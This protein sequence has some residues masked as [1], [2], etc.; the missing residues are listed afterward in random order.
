MSL[1]TVEMFT[2]GCKR[3]YM[4]VLVCLMFLSFGA[5][6]QHGVVFPQPKEMQLSQ[7]KIQ[8]KSVLFLEDKK[9]VQEAIVAIRLLSEQLSGVE[10]G[11]STDEKA[12]ISVVKNEDFAAES[13]ELT[14]Q[15]EKITITYA[16]Q[17]GLAYGLI[18]LIQLIDEG[19]K[20]PI[21]RI[22]DQPSFSYRGLHLDCSRHFWTVSEI[23]ILLNQMALLKLNRF[24]WHLTDDQGWRLEIKQYP[25][26]TEIGAWR[27][28]T[29]IG[30]FG[31]VPVQ[32]EHQKYGG[33]YTQED[34]KN[35]VAYALLLG[36]EVIP[37]IE[38]PG[39]ARAALAAYPE[40]SCTE[41]VLPVAGT[42]GV[43]EDVFC[44]KPQTT[45][46]LK[47]VLTEVA[48]IFPSKLIH[49]GGDECPKTQWEKCPQ[50]QALIAEKHLKNEHELQNYFISEMIQHLISL[51]KEAI[52]WDEIMEGGI[53]ANAKIMSWRGTEGGIAAAKA[54]HEVVMTPTSHC[55]F[56]YYQSG[57]L[58]E[59]LAIGGFL[60]LEKVYA[61]NP[62]PKELSAMEQG[63]ILGAQ[64][65]LWTE[66][67]NDF[68]KLTYQYF[69][70]L[71]ALSEVVW[72][73][74]EQKP[75]YSSFLEALVKYEFPRFEKMGLNYSTACLEASLQIEATDQ[76]IHCTTKASS[77]LVKSYFLIEDDDDHSVSNFDEVNM[78]KTD[79]IDPWNIAYV[80][81]YQG[82]VLRS[83]RVTLYSNLLI[84]T[85]VKWVTLPS[86]KYNVG[87]N[88]ALTNGIVGT[89]PWK[90]D[91][92]VGFENDT[93]QFEFA[94]T[95]EQSGALMT[96][97][98]LDAKGSWIHC[99]EKVCIEQKK[100]K[101]WK[102][103]AETPITQPKVQ[104]KGLFK[105]GVY[106][107]TVV[108]KEKIPVGY[109]GAGF[110]PWTFISEIQLER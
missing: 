99:P 79:K 100:G 21:G 15:K 41:K 48:L 69:P 91:Q 92:W 105:K 98:F 61:Y 57:H 109:D 34:A 54:K 97:S 103:I 27:D 31:D 102:T 84:G 65:N 74:A 56:D 20:I 62:V 66:Y 7:D 10:M 64:A 58:D 35:I 77:S 5:L 30:H 90:G 49:I 80:S 37:E 106:R 16:D 23:E 3:M 32:Y 28:S 75:N 63:Y 52:G 53:P 55:Y 93:V 36:I 22:M 26:L 51:K 96:I 110:T 87:G 88:L 85:P 11:I 9:D 2:F 95:K 108:N 104:L 83:N 45:E 67:V 73:T 70:R 107:V 29:L 39:H 46:F 4:R 12:D 71:V 33:F 13:Y 44:A 59:P 94:L 43:F 6:A 25:K 19:K 72:N 24:H 8:L 50:C 60:P 76:G 81:E 89:L 101:N 17:S 1:K 86:E 82:K 42:W 68:S 18:T 78:G 40:L 14:I 47:N 38:L